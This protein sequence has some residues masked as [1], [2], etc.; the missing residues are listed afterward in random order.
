MLFHKQ[1]IYNYLRNIQ[2]TYSFIK[3]HFPYENVVTYAKKGK[4][5]I[6]RFSCENN[7]FMYVERPKII[8]DNYM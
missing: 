8:S 1:I 4:D 2:P 5:D 7:K 6:Y 3:E